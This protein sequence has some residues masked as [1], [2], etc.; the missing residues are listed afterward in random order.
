M[1]GSAPAGAVR[2]A[3]G[4]PDGLREGDG[5]VPEPGA[6]RPIVHE[7]RCRGVLNR[8]A[9]PMPFR[10][11][12]NPYRG[13]QHACSY[14]YARPSHIA[15]DL[16]GGADF[17][18]HV[19]VKVNAPEVLRGELR[20]PGWQ[21]EAVTVGTIVDP[22]QPVE[23]R[24]RITRGLLAELAAARTPAHVITKNTM[25]VRDLDVLL[26][27]RARAGCVVMV[28]VTTLDAGLARRMEPGT[29]PPLARLAAVGRLAAAGI[30]A[31]VM[32]APLLPGLGD[33]ADALE[34]LAGA[35]AAHGARFLMGGALRLGPNIEPWFRP[36]LERE[37]PDLLPLYAELYPRGYVPRAY[38]ERVRARLAAAR[39]RH[40]LPAAPPAPTPAEEPAQLRL[41]WQAS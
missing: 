3:A 6:R 18:R 11:S 34:A 22:Y 40:G 36:F 24:Y 4:S 32:A 15:F 5:V 29:P 26:R 19:F 28:S 13:C 1:I 31:G 17:E 21:R 16:D 20:R 41:T 39:A 14:C 27:L 23:G 25:I 12:A 30:A 10:W 35:A 9:P 33:D 7:I 8:V 2:D 37:R 38:A